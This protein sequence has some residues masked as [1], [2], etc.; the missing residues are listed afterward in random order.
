MLS[1]EQKKTLLRLARD[2]ITYKL[3]R[4]PYFKPDDPELL[5][6]R[7]LFVSLHKN[8]ELRGC[9][10]YIQAYHD[11]INSVIEMAEKAAFHDPR[12]EAV[13]VDELKEL[14]IE[15]SLLSEM[16]QVNNPEQI[17]IGRDGLYLVHPLGSG[18][19]LPQDAVEWGW[20]LHTYLKQLRHKAGLNYG[21]HKDAT[22]VLY[23]FTAEVFSE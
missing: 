11:V 7:A 3:L 14:V 15:I 10:G 9:I 1:D 8:G 23:C 17:V 6:R 19:L 16:Q 18:L 12:F 2:A 13:T 20:D 21:S 4:I 22:A 5:V